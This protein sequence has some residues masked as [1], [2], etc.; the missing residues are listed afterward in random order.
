ME[1]RGACEAPQG[2]LSE[3]HQITVT[4]SKM[5][6]TQ[7]KLQE[8]WE[9]RKE[10]HSLHYFAQIQICVQKILSCNMQKAK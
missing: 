7:P 4:I 10:G 2:Q 1:R 8:H 6:P 5:S 3:G 9:A